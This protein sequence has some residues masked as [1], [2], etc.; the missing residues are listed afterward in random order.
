[1]TIEVETGPMF[2]GK[3]TELLTQAE[4]L[5]IAAHGHINLEAT[6]VKSSREIFDHVFDID[7]QGTIIL[8]EGRDLLTAIFV[9]EGQFFD[10]N[11]GKILE[12]IDH[13]Y[14][15]NL[16]QNLN[17]FCAGLDMDFRGEPFGP[18]PDIMAR[19]HKV[20]KLVAV[21]KE[22]KKGT[23]NNAQYTQRLINGEPANYDDSVVLVG[24]SES[25]TARCR[26]HHQVRNRPQP[27]I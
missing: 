21:C 13:F 14:L 2:S 18:M 10:K 20:N 15:E 11:L 26:K 6:A 17:I 8:K 27:K 7:D 16:G 22:C 19:A 5:A 24:A 4:R 12:F 23:P 9:D 25:Y 1:M 3:T